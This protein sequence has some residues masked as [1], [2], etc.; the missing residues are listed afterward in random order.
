VAG[1]AEPSR[2]NLLMNCDRAWNSELDFEEMVRCALGREATAGIHS[3]RCP[4]VYVGRLRDLPYQPPSNHLGCWQ[5]A[6]SATARHGRPDFPCLVLVLESPH[7]DE[8]DPTHCYTPWPA[9]GPT[10]RSIGR[11]ASRLSALLDVPLDTGLVLLNAIP[12]QCS[13]GNGG[14]GSEWQQRRDAVFSY[15]W[16]QASTKALFRARLRH[17]VR[18]GDIVVNACTKG[19]PRTKAR[20]RDL[21][22]AEMTKALDTTV[23]RFRMHH[24]AGWRWSDLAKHLLDSN[25]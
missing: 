11:Y 14:G 2:D 6:D 18:S 13:Q 25:S 10:G 5:L 7:V 4:D 23:T 3:L 15:S 9:N 22:E 19:L 8:F 24:P 1:Q 20:L 21:V 16:E 12:Y 17:W